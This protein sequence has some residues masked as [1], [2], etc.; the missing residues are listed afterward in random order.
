MAEQI[1]VPLK[2]HDQIEEI[3]PYLKKISKP[4]KVT[5]LFPSTTSLFDGFDGLVG[6]SK[7]NLRTRNT[8]PF[9][10]EKDDANVLWEKTKG[11]G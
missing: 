2:M 10:S 5:F 8:N 9:G 7:E 4:M 1:F 3:I 11:I 6:R